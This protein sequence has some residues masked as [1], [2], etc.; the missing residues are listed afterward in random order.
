MKK[1]GE[2]LG[3]GLI[4]PCLVKQHSLRGGE[5]CFPSATVRDKKWD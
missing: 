3:V 1:C 4:Y 2:Y 5:G